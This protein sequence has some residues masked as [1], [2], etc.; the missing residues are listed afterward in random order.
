MIS[1][2]QLE[3][4][5][6][7]LEKPPNLSALGIPQNLLIDIMLRLFY[8]EGLLTVRRIIDVIKVPMAIEELIKQLTDDKV[9]RVQSGNSGMGILGYLY[10]LTENGERRA[11]AAMERSLYIGPA[12]VPVQLYNE[13][14]DLQSI[15]N[16]GVQPD[17]VIESLQDMVLPEDFH[18]KIGPAVNTAAS[19]FIYGPSGNGKT[20]I[21]KKMA[22]LISDIEPIWLPYAITAG[23]QIIQIHDRLVH[24]Q[25][26]VTKQHTKIYGEVD[27]RFGL[28]RRP[29]VVVGGELKL[30]EL[31]LRFDPI[32]KIYEAP[33]HI[34]ANGGMF[35]ID[36]FG[37]QQARPLDMLNRWIVP[38][39][40]QVD[41]LR[42]KTGQTVVVPF[43][44]LIVFATNLNPYDL[45]EDAF[46]RRIQ[47]KV[48]VDSPSEENYRKIFELNCQLF[49]L[50]FDE[51]IYNYLVKTYYHDVG[52]D[53]QAVHPGDLLKIL[54]ALCE[55][56]DREPVLA[57]DLIDTACE[58]YFVENWEGSKPNPKSI[59]YYN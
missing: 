32:S 58:S 20:T 28:F 54:K 5:K 36:D 26:E 56:E 45:A 42:L 11:R 37:R 6:T 27:P 31:D 4:L 46:F 38:L 43:R 40:D 29:S 48:K 12:P 52:R 16:R 14:I 7:L 19:L 57:I 51:E 3:R 24:Q 8:S 10:S 21:A 39:D 44:Q 59:Q 49:D 47:I 22:E 34:K 55:Y 33:L 35:L 15:N 18:R 13:I 30:S 25:I 41:Y 17:K 53:F 1:S 2:P 23:G 50:E 9:I